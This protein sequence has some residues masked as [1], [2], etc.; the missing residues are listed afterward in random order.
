MFATVLWNVGYS[1]MLYTIFNKQRKS[2]T[3]TSKKAE[4]VPKFNQT[5]KENKFQHEGSS[6]VCNILRKNIKNNDII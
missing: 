6:N 4:V 1:V 5:E 3:Q 2:G